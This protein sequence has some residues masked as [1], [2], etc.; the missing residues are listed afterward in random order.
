VTPDLGPS[1]LASTPDDVTV[2]ARAVHACTVASVFDGYFSAVTRGRRTREY[3][4]LDLVADGERALVQPGA[5]FWLVVERVALCG[6]R[7]HVEG[8][9]ALAFRRPGVGSAEEAFA[10]RAG[11]GEVR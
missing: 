6:G 5:R 8:R 4:A 11:A 2:T 1:W 7:G 9:S 10:A 3:H